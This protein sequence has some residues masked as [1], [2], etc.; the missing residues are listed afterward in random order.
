MSLKYQSLDDGDIRF[1][2][3]DAKILTYNELAKVKTIE[4][5]LPKHKSYFVLL[6]PVTSETNG[7]WVCL[8]RYD[9][10]IEY[11]SS[12]GTKPDVEFSW[13]TSNYK[14]NPRH[15]SELLKKTKLHIVYNSIDF[16]SKK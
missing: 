4:Q 10:T 13:P 11:F 12:Y 5:L 9:K 14:D 8:T 6:Y 3:P 2:L 15:L 16:Q 1:Y 7:H